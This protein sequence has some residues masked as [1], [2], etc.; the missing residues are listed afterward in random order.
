MSTTEQFL[1]IEFE[2]GEG[3]S[4]TD[5]TGDEQGALDD[6]LAY[7]EGLMIQM[8]EEGIKYAYSQEVHKSGEFYLEL[9]TQ[10]GPNYNLDGVKVPILKH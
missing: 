1:V 4:S 2:N 7:V 10:E 9:R 8:E 6:A 5:Y 3:I